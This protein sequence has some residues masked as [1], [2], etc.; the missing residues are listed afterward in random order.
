MGEGEKKP[1]NLGRTVIICT[2][3]FIVTHREILRVKATTAAGLSTA[4]RFEIYNTFPPFGN[5]V[6]FISGFLVGNAYNISRVTIQLNLGTRLKKKK[7]Y[8]I[9]RTF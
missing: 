7:I 2:V 3:R 9:F 4:S 6:Y 8:N 5:P 1:V